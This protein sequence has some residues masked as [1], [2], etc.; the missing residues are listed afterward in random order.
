M[1]C[2]RA[3]LLWGSRWDRGQYLSSSG[4][5]C[6]GTCAKECD[7][8]VRTQISFRT[9]FAKELI[10]LSDDYRG[11]VPYDR[12]DETHISEASCKAGVLLHR[13]LFSCDSLVSRNFI[14]SL[15]SGRT[16]TYFSVK[17]PA[18]N[19]KLWLFTHSWNALLWEMSAALRLLLP[20][21]KIKITKIPMDCIDEMFY[22][23]LQHLSLKV[24]C[25]NVLMGACVSFPNI[26]PEPGAAAVSP[27]PPVCRA[28]GGSSANVTNVRKNGLEMDFMLLFCCLCTWGDGFNVK[29]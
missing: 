14:F 28:S 21:F 19:S 25:I 15:Q 29:F 18:L 3:V 17:L 8:F 4:M 26:D 7:V 11:L 23:V 5:F 9:N 20:L 2:L 22:E 27:C 24:S 6:A 13:P 10:W 12:S 16:L 1:H